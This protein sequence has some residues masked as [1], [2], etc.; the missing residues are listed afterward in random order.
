MKRIKVGHLI[1]IFSEDHTF[2]GVVVKIDD[3]TDN[4]YLPFVSLHVYDA[5][6]H[7][8]YNVCTTDSVY[9]DGDFKIIY[10]REVDEHHVVK[11]LKDYENM[12]IENEIEKPEIE[13][14]KNY[15][16]GTEVYVRTKKKWFTLIRTTAKMAFFDGG[17]CSLKN[18]TDTRRK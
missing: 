18:I 11:L 5:V 7:V 12:Q 3:H 16:D 17:R 14:N 4:T 2:E 10:L 8:P 6:N 15:N 13:P 9:K 1:R